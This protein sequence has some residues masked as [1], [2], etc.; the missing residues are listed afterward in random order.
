M[1]N[2][3]QLTQECIGIPFFIC[4]RR[5]NETEERRLYHDNRVHGP[6]KELCR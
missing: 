5:I 2:N 4:Y 3:V 6:E 1:Y